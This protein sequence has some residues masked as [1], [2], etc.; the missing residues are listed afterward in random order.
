MNDI[1]PLAAAFFVG[2]L[3]GAVVASAI[4][5]GY[6]KLLRERLCIREVERNAFAVRLFKL[7]S[8][9]RAAEAKNAQA[10]ADDATNETEARR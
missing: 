6:V 2:G 10:T 1:L 5:R 3:F 4:S 7:E 8:A 9:L